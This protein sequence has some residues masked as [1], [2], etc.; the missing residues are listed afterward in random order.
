VDAPLFRVTL[1]AGDRTGL[2][3]MSQVM[4]DKVASVPRDAIGRVIGRCSPEEIDGVGEALRGWL[5][6]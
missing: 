4:A 1:P 5:S 6:V 3:T 2:T